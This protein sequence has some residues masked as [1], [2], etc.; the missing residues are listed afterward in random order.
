MLEGGFEGTSSAFMQKKKRTPKQ[1]RPFLE[2][3]MQ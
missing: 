2:V 3:E 1:K